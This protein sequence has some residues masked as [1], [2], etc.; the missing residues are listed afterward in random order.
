VKVDNSVLSGATNSVRNDAEFTTRIGASK[1]E[2]G[3]VSSNNGVLECA[4]SYDGTNT[5]LGALCTP[6]TK[7]IYVATTGGDFGTITAALN[8]ITDN[9]S[10][11]RY[12]IKVGPGNYIEHVFMKQYVDIEGAGEEQTKIIFTG[13]AGPPI[14]SGTVHGASNAEL[15]S[16]TVE[17][18]GANSLA[19]AVYNFGVSPSLLHVTLLASGGTN[20]SYGMVIGN[21]ATP[22]L[23]DVTINITGNAINTGIYTVDSSPSMNDLAITS[24]G[25]TGNDGILSIGSS[26]DLD[27]NNIIVTVSGGTGGNVGIHSVSVTATM[28]NVT[29]I[30]S[31]GQTSTG[32]LNSVCSPTMNNVTATGSGASDANYGVHNS[33][34]DTPFSPILNN[35]IA[36]AS[37][38]ITA[39]GLYNSGLGNGTESPIIQ[40]S[41]FSASG[42]T[43]NYGMYNDATF[44]PNTV[45]VDDSTLMGSTN[46]IR[47]DNNFTVR[48]G[49][50]KL[51]G[52]AV[53]PNGG[54]ITCAGVHDEVYT[55]FP[56]TCP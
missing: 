46:S 42:G 38:G 44:S 23:N 3:A 4:A 45:R 37:G 47:N 11:N 41:V 8:S 54:I 25:G 15:R 27:M 53:L 5:R 19:V 31:G 24:S 12:L 48:V 50:S 33:A 34:V 56:S 18:I 51:D 6:D 7:T 32:V 26:S 1:L 49:S 17:N 35:V 52:G 28:N 10:V 13:S 36:T 16:L 22:R 20:T 40:H 21:S 2:G 9:S 30:A 14:S 39:A 55:F 43:S 29:S